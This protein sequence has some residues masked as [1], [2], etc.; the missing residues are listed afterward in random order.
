MSPAPF[1][2]LRRR[3]IGA[4]SALFAARSAWSANAYPARPVTLIVPFAPGGIADLTARIVA[5][6]M[7]RDLGQPIV[8]DNRPSAGNI[9][10]SAAVAQ[11]RPD[12][13]TLLLLSNGN[14]V[15]ASLFRKL[16]FD[17]S[18]DFAPVSTL[19]FFDLVVLAHGGSRY[20]TLAD[21]LDETRKRPGK[22]TIATIA[23]GS[24]QNLAAEL[25]KST[26]GIDALI[27][28]YKA[29]P[30][31]LSAVRSGEIDIAF[32]ILGPMLSQI[33][34]GVVRPLAVTSQVR[35]PGLPD[36]PCARET[37]GLADYW[38]AS[39]NALAAPAATPEPIIE[40]LAQATRAAIAL[41]TVH[42]KLVSLGVRPAA[43]S[44]A[45]LRALLSGEIARW[46]AVIVAA[47]IEPQ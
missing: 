22:V 15:S 30:A 44:P 7:G 9:V 38:V 20:R 21:V 11:A 16:P 4:A 47:H 8:V 24:T 45:E 3:L 17:V 37:A 29:S 46:R 5:E 25:F 19:G 42:A 18:R 34:A 31:V 14:A 41:P 13:Y 28:P 6:A 40:R 33:K 12:G 23:P 35:Y 39:W 36:V 10:G 1:N 26:A 32:E 27:V 2:V 43:G